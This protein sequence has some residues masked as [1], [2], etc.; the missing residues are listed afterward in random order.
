M[1]QY[2]HVHPLG[3]VALVPFLVAVGL[4]IYLGFHELLYGHNPY[5]G[6]NLVFHLGIVAL[7]LYVARNLWYWSV[8]KEL[9]KWQKVFA[10]IV[11]CALIILMSTLMY[12]TFT[13]KNCLKD[14]YT[15]QAK[16]K[17]NN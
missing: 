9:A 11:Y 1:D 17:C 4:F 13:F 12:N 14:A 8:G 2:R 15:V 5:G 16:A 10:V 3:I 7:L 6:I